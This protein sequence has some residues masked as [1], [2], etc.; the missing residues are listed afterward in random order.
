MP[1]DAET[2][3]SS[4]GRERPKAGLSSIKDCP[5]SM[6]E[7]PPVFIHSY[8]T[9]LALNPSTVTPI[10]SLL[11]PPTQP[12]NNAF[13]NYRR[14]RARRSPHSPCKPNPQIQRPGTTPTTILPAQARD[15]QPTTRHHLR[16]HRQSLRPAGPHHRLPYL[17][18]PR[19]HQPLALRAPR[20]R[21]R[22]PVP[23]VPHP[24]REPDHCPRDL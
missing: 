13:L 17:R 10:H 8:N 9:L 21:R 2:Y 3:A 18:L 19:L 20:T 16:L 15:P 11:L 1:R 12:R 5:F 23:T 24:Q 6:F 7:H 4:S 22:H 14:P